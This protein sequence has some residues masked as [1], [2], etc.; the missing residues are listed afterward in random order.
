MPQYF[1]HPGCDVRHRT[2]ATAERCR[3]GLGNPSSQREANHARAQFAAAERLARREEKRA[4]R[5][6]ERATEAAAVRAAQARLNQQDGSQLP[7]HEETEL[8]AGLPLTES[9]VVNTV[10]E[11]LKN[12]LRLAEVESP[13]L[14]NRGIVRVRARDVEAWVG[15]AIVEDTDVL[16][17]AKSASFFG[18]A[19]FFSDRGYSKSAHL[20]AKAKQVALF[21]VDEADNVRP[22]NES[23]AARQHAADHPVAGGVARFLGLTISLGVGFV[24]LA[25]MAVGVQDTLTSQSV[26]DTLVSAL[27]LLFFMGVLGFASAL[28]AWAGR[29]FYHFMNDRFRSRQPR[30]DQ[31]GHIEGSDETPAPPRRGLV[32]P[33]A[34]LTMV[35]G[36]V[37]AGTGVAAGVASL[38]PEVVVTE[39]V[40]G[41]TID[42][43][44]DGEERRV[45]LL[46]VDA[47]ETAHPDKDIEC[48]G[49]EAAAFLRQL[50]PPGTSVDLKYDDEHEDRY[51]RELAGVFIENMLVNAEIAREGLGVPVV[52]GANDRFYNQVRAAQL[53]ARSAQRGLYNPANAC[54]VPGQIDSLETILSKESS[55][56]DLD[57]KRS[58]L[59]ELEA[60]ILVASQLS[61][62]LAGDPDSFHARAHDATTAVY[63]LE[64]VT[65]RLYDRKDSVSADI[66]REEQALQREEAERLR[67][68]EEQPLPTTETQP[69]ATDQRAAPSDPKS[70]STPGYDGYTGC[71]AYG[72]GYIPNA[73]DES[74]RPYT[75]IDCTSKVPIP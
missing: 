6:E 31:A 19:L 56:E 57:G 40:D 33:A 53:E 50:L 29:P 54:T 38:P 41:D 11:Y 43:T 66:K 24:S 26:A 21:L 62:L 37:L 16:R 47:P 23:A 61:E 12:G 58:R 7:P 69:L 10:V 5:K 46:N 3:F 1:T 68:A 13:V 36:L 48:L 32:S 2:R 59:A 4:L 71:R 25:L 67:R 65:R 42:V 27:L 74:G 63:R 35:A 51:G 17:A 72:G 28:A 30:N 45:R 52:Y 70:T 9:A 75:K 14:S 44:I 64:N 55:G 73:V 60:A 49:P 18:H 8:F 15:S 34:V 39:I 20:V 22:A